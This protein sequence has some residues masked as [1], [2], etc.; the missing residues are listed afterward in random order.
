MT[1]Q[2]TD[3]QHAAIELLITGVAGSEVARAVGVNPSTVSRW[4]RNDPQFIAA[5]ESARREVFGEA[6]DRLASLAADAVGVLGDVVKDAGAPPHL[7]VRA[8]LAILGYMAR[9]PRE[10]DQGT[11]EDGL[12]FREM[13]SVMGS[14]AN[15][16]N[17]SE[18]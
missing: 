4:R 12:H 10:V 18:G 17:N 9:Q 8:S 14:V 5:L 15:E 2:L 16:I 3:Q 13:M 11:I 1:K 6:R 7:R